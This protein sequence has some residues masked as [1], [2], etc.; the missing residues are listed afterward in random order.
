MKL[1]PSELGL[2]RDLALT[3]DALVNT[4]ADALR[5]SAGA[6]PW[7]DVPA[8]WAAL[9]KRLT[10]SEDQQAFHAVVREL[11]SIQAHSFLTTLDGGTALAE[12][13]LLSIQDEQGHVFKRFL[14]E[15]WPGASG[16]VD[17]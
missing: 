6:Q 12:S 10:T 13:T 3:R 2:L 9:S 7:T 1:Q 16:D 14:H 8:S 15:S 11:L 5:P 4:A 17:G